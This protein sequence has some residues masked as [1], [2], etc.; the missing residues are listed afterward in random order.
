MPLTRLPT[1]AALVNIALVTETYPPEINGVAMTLSQLAEGLREKGHTLQIVRPLQKGEPAI[2][3]T[4]PS[5]LTTWGLPIPGYADLRFGL[6]CRNRLVHAWR[7]HRPDIVHV[8]T[9]G[10]LGLSAIR[11]AAVLGIPVT[12]TFHT[13]FHSYSEHY[14]A[15]WITRPVLAFL[16]WIHNQTRCTMAPTRELANQ[17]AAEGFR[18]MD[19]FGRGVRLATF[20]PTR[21][22]AALRQSWGAQPDDPVVVHVSRLAAEKNYQLLARSYEAI[23]AAYP[24]A[25]FVIAGD[26]PVRRDL[27]RSMPY[28]HFTGAIPLEDRPSLARVYASADIFLYPSQTETYGNVTTEAMACGNAVLSFNY[29]AA[30]LH[31]RHGVNGLVANLGDDDSFI[32]ESLRLAGDAALRQRL[33]AAASAGASAFDWQPIIDRFESILLHESAA[34]HSAPS[35]R[36]AASASSA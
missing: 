7:R 11:A 3:A 29:A 13:N 27:E 10:P 26:G 18:N 23:R 30:A 17:L 22:D 12:S 20:N 4:T 8:A 33:G 15:S 16:R 5:L 19:V 31:I 21:R 36:I 24:N 14:N 9:E 2:L 6:P 35:P 28:A 34:A 1:R 32:S 25:Q